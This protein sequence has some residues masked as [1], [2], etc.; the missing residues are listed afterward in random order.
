MS[1]VEIDVCW[2]NDGKKMNNGGYNW[3]NICSRYLVLT[4]CWCLKG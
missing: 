4:P 1:R 2:V 3:Y